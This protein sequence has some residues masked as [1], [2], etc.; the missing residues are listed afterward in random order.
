[1]SYVSTYGK[2]YPTKSEYKLRQRNYVNN[3]HSIDSFI[4]NCKDSI[5]DEEITGAVPNGC[6]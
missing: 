1:M 2:S 6:T 5:P 4:K 3:M